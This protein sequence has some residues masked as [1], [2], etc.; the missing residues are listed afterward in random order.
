MRTILTGPRVVSSHDF[1]VRVRAADNDLPVTI[2]IECAAIDGIIGGYLS[3]ETRWHIVENNLMALLAA[4]ES[5]YIA[6]AAEEGE[7]LGGRFRHITLR[8]KDLKSGML[9]SLEARG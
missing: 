9:R 7:T 4:A 1:F 3:H 6:G 2:D 8:M 5:R